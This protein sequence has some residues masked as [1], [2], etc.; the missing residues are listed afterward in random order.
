MKRNDI[1]GFVEIL[2]IG[3]LYCMLALVDTPRY[4]KP[5]SQ[6]NRNP[7]IVYFVLN[8]FCLSDIH[9]RENLRS[10]LPGIYP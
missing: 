2:L 9:M 3:P 7:P 4:L 1:F 10:H 5:G 8:M 6:F